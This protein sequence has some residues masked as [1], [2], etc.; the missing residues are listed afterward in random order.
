MYDWGGL[1]SFDNPNGIDTFKMSFG[2][3]KVIYYDETVIKSF[4]YKLLRKL[5]KK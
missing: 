5:L 2:G 3:E 1:S 4:K